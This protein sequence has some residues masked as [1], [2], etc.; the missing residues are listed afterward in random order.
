MS[1]TDT[2]YVVIDMVALTVVE[3]EVGT[4]VTT[5]VCSTPEIQKTGYG[6]CQTEYYEKSK[7]IHINKRNRKKKSIKSEI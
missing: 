4:V 1:E 7:I 5:P 6:S 2:G 3:V